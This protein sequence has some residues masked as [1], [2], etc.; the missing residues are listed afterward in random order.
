M[1]NIIIND[2]DLLDTEIEKTSIK[3]RS[4]LVSSRKILI[5]NYGG[6]YLLPGGSVDNKEDCD[7]AIVRELKEE[8]GIKYDYKDLKKVCLLKHYQRDYPTRSNKKLNRLVFTH[9]YLG[10]YKGINLNKIQRTEKEIQDGF[11]LELLDCDEIMQYIC[12]NN[13][14][15]KRKKYFDK[16]LI[17]ILKIVNASHN[18]CEKILRRK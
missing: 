14:K 7:T 11:K 8:T 9:Y 1:I 17:E 3:V 4:I 15:N 16:E 10:K 13:S 18:T 12:L 5:A 6:V 2:D